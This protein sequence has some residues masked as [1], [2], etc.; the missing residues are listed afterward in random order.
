M[1]PDT[2]PS[3]DTR[4]PAESQFLGTSRKVA[5]PPLHP[6]FSL[7]MQFCITCAS[8]PPGVLKQ[9]LSIRLPAESQMDANRLQVQGSGRPPD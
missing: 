9:S 4:Q 2:G 7:R 1:P 5:V 8:P 3:L 6:L